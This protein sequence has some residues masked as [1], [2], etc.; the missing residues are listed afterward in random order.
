MELTL[1]L[2]S[3]PQYLKEGLAVNFAK[4]YS[5]VFQVCFA[6]KPRKG[7]SVH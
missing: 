6:N 7:S 4:H 1:V 2:K 5:D 3:L